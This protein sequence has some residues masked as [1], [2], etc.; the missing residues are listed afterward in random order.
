MFT[1]VAVHGGRNPRG[2]GIA[3]I[4]RVK[5]RSAAATMPWNRVEPPARRVRKQSKP[6]Q[7]VHEEYSPNAAEAGGE[8]PF[9]ILNHKP[10]I[11][12]FENVEL[13]PSSTTTSP[14]IQCSS[15]E[16][17]SPKPSED[18]SIRNNTVSNKHSLVW[19]RMPPAPKTFCIDPFWTF[20]IPHRPVLSTLVHHRKSI[21][22]EFHGIPQDELPP[23]LEGCRL[24]LTASKAFHISLPPFPSWTKAP[25]YRSP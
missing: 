20:S 3:A 17:S 13:S 12:L 25:R 19:C 21:S 1:F 16:G 14:S 8:R 5:I 9:G 11:D 7:Q 15:Q 4:D 24:V 2:D 10:G 6:K 23:C 22:M 18:G